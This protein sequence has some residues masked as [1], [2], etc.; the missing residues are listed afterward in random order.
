MQVLPRCR[1]VADRRLHLV[2]RTRYDEPEQQAEQREEG[3]VVERDAER[4]R[5]APL[6]EPLHARPHSRGDDECQEE[7]AEQHLKFPKCERRHDHAGDDER[8]DEGSSGGL[9][10]GV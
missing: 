4:P 8:R 9:P 7:Q 5:H 10:L 1:D 2:E 6:R 3:Q